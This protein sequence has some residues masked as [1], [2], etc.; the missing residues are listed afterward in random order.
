LGEVLQC[1]SHQVFPLGKTNALRN[2][3]FGFQQLTDE[4]ITEAWERHQDYI[5]ACPHH[6]MEESFII[7]RFYHGLI[8]SAREHIDATV[9]GSFFT[10][11]IEKAHKLVQKMSSNQS[12]DE[13]RT[14]T[15]TRKV[16]QLKEVD[17]HTATIDLM[18]KLEN[19]GLDHLKLVDARVT[20][21]ECIDIGHMGINYPMVPQDVNFIGNS[22]NG[23]R[24]NQSFNVG[25]NKPSF[26]FDN[27]QHGGN[28]QNFN[29]NEP[30]PRDIIRDLVRINGEVGKKIHG[31]DKLLENINAKMDNFT[32]ATQNQLS[33]NKM[34]ET[35]I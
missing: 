14:Q 11:S 1:I 29:R 23:F 34:L 10:L 25:W 26:P 21:E 33:F 5:S 20:C 7:Q 18:K 12:W 27:R 24:P 6:G 2:K 19:P 16:H 8:R 31:T 17:M 15:N 30:S 13:E 9:G 4:T 3:I 32:V 35:Q 28:G 22:N